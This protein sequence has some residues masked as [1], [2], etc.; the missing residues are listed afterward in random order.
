MASNDPREQLRER[1]GDHERPNFRGSR[2]RLWPAVLD[3]GEGGVFAE[4]PGL[5]ISQETHFH[6][7]GASERG[8]PWFHLGGGGCKLEQQRLNETTTG[9]HG[10][11]R[12]GR[13]MTDTVPHEQNPRACHHTS[14]VPP[15]AKCST[16]GP[17]VNN[18]PH[19]QFLHRFRSNGELRREGQYPSLPSP[20]PRRPD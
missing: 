13:R 14:G 8:Q 1:R 9:E 3:D 20:P 2:G 19:R 10:V 5:F 16:D 6:P 17:A 4:R 11:G 7:R 12:V 15:L 18:L